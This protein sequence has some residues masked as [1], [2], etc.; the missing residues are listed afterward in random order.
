[1]ITP[2]ATDLGTRRLLIAAGEAPSVQNTQP[3]RFR[4]VR[5][6]YVELSADPDRRLT[7]GDPRARSLHVSCGA[8]L[9]NLRLAV[10]QTGHHPLVWLMPEPGLL[11]AVRL[12]ETEAPLPAERRLYAAIPARR[13]N[14]EPYDDRA[15]PAGIIGDMKIAASREGA[16]LVVLDRTGVHELLE[17]AAIAEDELGR[18]GDYQ[19]ELTRWAVPDYVRGPGPDGDPPVTRNLGRRYRSATFEARPRIAVLTTPGD[20]PVD[21]LRAGQ[22]LERV[23]LVATAAGLSTS[24]L[25]QPLDLRDMR[26]HTDPRHRRGHPQMIIRFGFGPPVPRAPRRPVTEL[27][28]HHVR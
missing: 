13:T 8:A 16:C 18:D 2:L 20:G 27:E 9:L 28:I 1:M 15:V 26:G 21:W 14:R 7:V 10:R 6:E 17:Y 5:R 19:A 23:L 3:W 22:A 12:K 4:V 24:F 25:N 11:A